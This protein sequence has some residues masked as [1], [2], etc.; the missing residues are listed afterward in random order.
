MKA[1][2]MKISFDEPVKFTVKTKMRFRERSRIVHIS[3]HLT[4]NKTDISGLSHGNGW[5]GKAFLSEDELSEA[6]HTAKCAAKIIRK[7]ITI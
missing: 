1:G 5:A 6:L 3:A 7:A 4:K 2:E